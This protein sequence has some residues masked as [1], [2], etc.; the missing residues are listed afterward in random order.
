MMCQRNLNII[1]VVQVSYFYSRIIR[2]KADKVHRAIHIRHGMNIRRGF[3]EDK[4]ELTLGKYSFQVKNRN[5]ARGAV[6][7]DTNEGPRLMRE[8]ERIQGHFAFENEVKERL[9]QRGMPLTDRVVYNIEGDPVTEWDSGE[10]YVVYQWYYGDSCDY[11]SSQGLEKAAANLG[12]LHKQLRGMSE[13][14]VPIEENLFMRYERRNRELKRVYHF[15]KGKK[16]KNE[17]ELCALSCYPE[18]FRKAEQAAEYLQ[19]SVY[20]QKYGK[21]TRDVCHGEYNYHNLIY[22][23]KGIATT[24]FEHAHYGMQLMDLAYFLRKAMEKNAWQKEKG[25]AILEGYRSEVEM[26]AEEYEFLWTVLFYPVKFWKL[27]SQYMNGKK[28]WISDKN[29]EKLVSVREKEEAKDKFLGET[30][31]DHWS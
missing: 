5:R 11:R 9:A 12:Q 27:M 17:F 30:P 29:M 7:L 25:K 26:G 6:L 4:Q 1:F 31:N 10:K 14:P 16:R 28:S 24:N 3:V 19:R 21:E 23:K 8:Y 13:E 18:F 20:W 22:T 2:L 15:M